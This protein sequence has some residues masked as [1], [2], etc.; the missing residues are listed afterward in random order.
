MNTSIFSFG[1]SESRGKLGSDDK[2]LG[3]LLH[4]SFLA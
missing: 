2:D 1:N 3:G 4:K